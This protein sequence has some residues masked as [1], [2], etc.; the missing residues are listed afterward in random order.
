MGG[1][2][3]LGPHHTI[4]SGSQPAAGIGRPA[5]PLTTREGAAVHPC[6]A[7]RASG[8]TPNTGQYRM[9]TL[10]M[11]RQP[12]PCRIP[13]PS[14]SARIQGLLTSP[15][16]SPARRYAGSRALAASRL[17]LLPRASRPV[18]WWQGATWPVIAYPC[19]P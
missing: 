3:V 7:G 15:S 14:S 6:L 18:V 10:S 16:P 5:P 4:G 19:A 1:S 17:L 13:P 12:L 2:V 9:E 11:R 8:G